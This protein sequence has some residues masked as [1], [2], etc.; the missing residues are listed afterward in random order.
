MSLI[1]SKRQGEGEIGRVGE[2][3][4]LVIINNNY[5]RLVSLISSINKNFEQNNLQQILIIDYHSLLTSQQQLN[6]QENPIF[7]QVNLSICSYN[8]INF[9][10]QEI[11]NKIQG[12][13]V[14]FLD[15]DYTPD[16]NWLNNIELS[17][18]DDR[19]NFVVGKT[20]E[21]KSENDRDLDLKNNTNININFEQEYLQSWL[22]ILVTSAIRT[23]WLKKLDK[24]GNLLSKNQE[25]YSCLCRI[26]Q[27][28]E[29][30]ITPINPI[31]NSIY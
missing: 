25:D 3:F 31:Y 22:K 23:S 26:L 8:S 7:K 1:I 21:N 11:K 17:F 5:D 9:I 10:F 12:E 30:E 16:R 6:L 20:I 29:A 15:G 28:L 14:L 18:Q 19:T 27:E 2:F 4:S 24:L 13:I